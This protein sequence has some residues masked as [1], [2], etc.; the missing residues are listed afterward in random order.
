MM[1]RAGSER[2]PLIFCV[3]LPGQ[4]DA[5]GPAVYSYFSLGQESRQKAPQACGA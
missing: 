4:K 5:K 2:D 3:L 1:L